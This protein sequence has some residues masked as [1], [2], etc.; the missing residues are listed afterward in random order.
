[1]NIVFWNCQDLRP[2]QKVLQNYLLENQIDIL[3]PNETLLTP[4]FKFHLPGY[5]IYKK[6]QISSHQGEG[7]GGHSHPGEKT[8]L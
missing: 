6:G 8:L 2:K 1:M 7:G 4:K 3:A 5:D